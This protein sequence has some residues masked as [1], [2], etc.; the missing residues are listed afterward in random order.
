MYTTITTTKF[1]PTI[2]IIVVHHIK[3][4]AFGLYHRELNNF[5]NVLMSYQH[6]GSATSEYHTACM[7]TTR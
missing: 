6:T 1:K 5:W 3:S 4:S 7:L 2:N